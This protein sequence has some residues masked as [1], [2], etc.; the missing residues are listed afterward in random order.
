ML[1]VD[2]GLLELNDFSVCS[3]HLTPS[4]QSQQSGALITPTHHPVTHTPGVVLQQN[5]EKTLSTPQS[6]L[7]I[8]CR[9]TALMTT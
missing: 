9:L 1:A 2:G 3:G 6:S 7:I 8:K 5:S 4:V